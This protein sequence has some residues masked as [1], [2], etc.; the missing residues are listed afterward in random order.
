MKILPFFTIVALLF[1]FATSKSIGQSVSADPNTGSLSGSIHLWTISEGDLS[2]PVGLTYYSRGIKVNAGEGSVGVGWSLSAGGEVIREVKGLP[3]DYVGVNP[4]FRF[5]WL[6]SNFAKTANDFAPTG[7]QNYTVCTDEI[8][9]WNKLTSFGYTNDTEPDM[10]SFH[11]PGLSGQ[12]VFDRT[13]VIRTIPYQDVKIVVTRNS[14]DS[15]INQIVIT[16]NLGVVYTFNAGDKVTRTANKHTSTTVVNHQKSPFAYYYN[17]NTTFYQSWYLAS[18][19]S[20]QGAS[21][22][23]GYTNETQE[24]SVS[25]YRE[26]NNTTGVIDTIYSISDNIKTKSLAQISADNQTINFA[27]NQTR[28]LGSVTVNEL[29][30]SQSKKFTLQYAYVKSTVSASKT[31]RA[32]LKSLTQEVNCNA[33]PGY[34]F[35]YYGVDLVAKTTDIPFDT[36]LKQDQFGYYNNAGTS[37]VPEVYVK[38]GDT[39][40]DGE[41]Y[42]IAPATSYSLIAASASRGVDSSKVY[43]GSLEK[44]ILPTG[45]YTRVKYEPADY[46]DDVAAGTK[47]GAG[48]RVKSIKTSAS[49]PASDV[50]LK[51]RYKTTA[52]QSSGR[53]VYRPMFAIA[54]ASPVLVP[55][56]LAP[57]DAIL[58]SRVEVFTTGRGKVEY[59]FQVPG[60][61][62]E[63]SNTTNGTFAA[64]LSRIARPDPGSGSCVSIGSLRSQYYTYPYAQNTNY[65]FNRGL[66][67]TVT[68]YSSA[69][70]IVRKSTYTYTPTTLSTITISG[71]RFESFNGVFQF[72]KYTMLT[73]LNSLAATETT[74]VYDQTDT[75]NAKNVSVLATNT[76]NSNQMLRQIAVTN[77]D[78]I[79]HYTLFKYAKDYSSGGTDNQSLMIY[80]LVNANRHGTLIEAHTKEG[81]NATGASLTLYDTFGGRVLPSQILKWADTTAFVESSIS[82]TFSKSSKY[83]TTAYV[84]SYDAVG[85]VTSGHDQAR[86][87]SGVI[88]G[89]YNTVAVAEIFN[90]TPGQ[91]AFT[92]FEVSTSN[93]VTADGTI[94]TTDP[95]S[96]Q[97][98]IVLTG[99]QVVSKTSISKA[100]SP[101]YRFTCRAKASTTGSLNVQTKTS[102][103]WTTGA[104]VN[105]TTAGSWQFLEGRVNV[106][107]INNDAPFDFQVLVNGSSPSFTL[108]DV[109]FYP[110]T[111]DLVSHN[112]NLVIGGMSDNDSRGGAGFMEYD[113]MGRLRFVKNQDR[114]LVMVKD[115][116]YKS[117]TGILPVSQ[118][119]SSLENGDIYTNTAVTFAPVTSCVSGVTYQWYI[120]D[121]AAGTSSTMIN[122]F[123]L[124][125]DYRVKL[126]ATYVYGTSE[127]EVIIHPKAV[128]TGAITLNSGESNSLQCPETSYSSPRHFNISISGD[129]EPANTTY[130]WYRTDT[131]GWNSVPFGG[132]SSTATYTFGGGQSYLIKCD[133]TS[134][135]L[136]RKTGVHEA[137]SLTKVFTMTWSGTYPCS[138]N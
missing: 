66:P 75:N 95:W 8:A 97:K 96:G 37:Q 133:V 45:G 117:A 127:T 101:Y 26:L 110:E 61:Y 94:S 104:T 89:Q 71:V 107:G 34:A 119:T 137:V 122:T 41:R 114:D 13:K 76:Y 124:N 129:F 79:T 28:T 106:S 5:G 87:N 23:F 39:G 16:N 121:V 128:I 67:L 99:S 74:Q 2:A 15:L 70:K 113:G 116:H 69:G 131:N 42:R 93:G 108:D 77:S 72:A 32:F 123:T 138:L 51:Y 40:V 21:I 111:A 54:D 136:N 103:S 134:T 56:N 98:C 60:V 30:Y 38:S 25:R 19:V 46:Y 9:D 102:S 90:A 24:T 14:T 59:I 85:H 132:N 43:F 3:D 81:S 100:N 55:D 62:P 33:F 91:V 18:I 1:A 125:K 4:D 88:M 86:T 31:K 64:S 10:F 29:S 12:F 7:D 44:I 105:Y 58:Y 20:P 22:S 73:N 48:I 112:S 68:E 84:D 65:D 130:Y 92:D 126:V 17:Y 57:D 11:A 50:V 82:G 53:W 52:N 47:W 118:F 115:Y 83:Y 36:K 80:N 49:D 78:N 120:D 63:T 109:A 27:W 35:T 6:H 135:S